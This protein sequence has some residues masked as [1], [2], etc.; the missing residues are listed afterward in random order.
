M[1]IEIKCYHCDKD[2]IGECPGIQGQVEY[3]ECDCGCGIQIFRN[4][5][6]KISID[7]Y[8]QSP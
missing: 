6:D 2:L 8:G 5:D 4:S 7:Q 1:Q 3:L